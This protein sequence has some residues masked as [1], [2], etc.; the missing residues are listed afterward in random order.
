MKKECIE[1]KNTE[2]LYK[3]E[4][5]E[6]VCIDCLNK[7]AKEQNEIK[8]EIVGY[9]KEFYNIYSPSAQAKTLQSIAICILFENG[10][11][12]KETENKIKEMAKEMNEI[13]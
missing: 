6:Y 13:E 7:L 5:G 4:N 2:K 11:L 3:L 12:D 10:L 9:L 8:E 1:C